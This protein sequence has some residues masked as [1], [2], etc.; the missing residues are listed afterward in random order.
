M[1][2]TSYSINQGI[3]QA[4]QLADLGN[5]GIVSKYDSVD[6]LGVSFGMGLV[7]GTNDSEVHYPQTANDKMV[8]ISVLVQ[9]KEQQLG[10][11]IV[12]YKSGDLISVLR[13]GRIWVLVDGPVTASSLVYC[14]FAAGT[15]TVL[16][17]FRADADTGSAFLVDGASFSSS[18]VA[19]G[20][21]IID[22]NLPA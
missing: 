9:H 10:T 5:S 17:S 15:G 22:I 19:G 16:G 18:A 4:G 21:A 11:G 14:R 13:K 2:Q 1:S 12:N 3:S 6:A 8:G 20:L 7:Q